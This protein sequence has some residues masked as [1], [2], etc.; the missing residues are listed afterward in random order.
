[1]VSVG[2]ADDGHPIVLIHQEYGTV[3][4]R[5]APHGG[6]SFTSGNAVRQVSFTMRP[7][8][9]RELAE[10]LLAVLDNESSSDG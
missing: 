10:R 6:F 4:V 3:E 5:H 8:A 2:G 1:M 7:G 9:A